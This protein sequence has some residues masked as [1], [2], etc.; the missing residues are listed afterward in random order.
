MSRWQLYTP[1]FSLEKYKTNHGSMDTLKLNLTVYGDK[2]D[3]YKAVKLYVLENPK[4]LLT[5]EIDHF[6][7]Y[8]ENHPEETEPN[9]W[10]ENYST[11]DEAIIPLAKSVIIHQT[12]GHQYILRVKSEIAD[13]TI[14]YPQ[15]YCSL[16]R[17]ELP[18]K[19][20]FVV[21]EPEER[22]FS[23]ETST[24]TLISVPLPQKTYQLVVNCGLDN[25]GYCFDY[26]EVAY[27]A[28]CNSEEAFMEAVKEYI[29]TGIPDKVPRDQQDQIN[30]LQN[31]I[32]L[33]KHHYDDS[34]KLRQFHR[35]NKSLHFDKHYSYEDAI[36][37]ILK[38]LLTTYEEHNW[39]PERKAG[40]YLP[41][42]CKII[43]F[44]F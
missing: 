12:A 1:D 10:R 34:A 24:P 39:A 22:Y 43:S 13:D 44:Y 3:F 36:V 32:E 30:E 19:R 14:P 35:A 25:D 18:F 37:P 21:Y 23:L 38:Y 11:Y 29:L 16:L 4:S 31:L 26:S 6:W 2:S 28:K 41:I 20:G 17:R 9:F 5:G 40:I 33:I 7:N 15:G 27:E 8:N 42:C